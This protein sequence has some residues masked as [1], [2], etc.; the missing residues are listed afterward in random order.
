M[1]IENDLGVG[2]HHRFQFA[3]GIVDRDSHF[4]RRHVVFLHAHGR[5]L[6]HFT[7]ER[8]VL[9]RLNL[10]AG[11]LSQIDLADIAL[12]DFAFDVNLAGVAERHH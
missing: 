12:V 10:D 6:R 7:G 4:E 11:G 2:R 1:L 5:N 3:P 8:F 9:E